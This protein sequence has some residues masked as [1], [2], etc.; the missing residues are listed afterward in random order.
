MVEHGWISVDKYM[1]VMRVKKA[2]NE[3]CHDSLE[4]DY[5]LVW[6]GTNVEIAN[7]N[8]ECGVLFWMN[9]VVEEVKVTHWMPMPTPPETTH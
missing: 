5:V 3:D 4:S 9:R 6:N 1:P 8:F 7:L 2:K